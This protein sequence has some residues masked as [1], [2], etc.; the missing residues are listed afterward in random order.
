M[1]DARVA[2]MV[3]ARMEDPI[4]ALRRVSE[5]IDR[6]P[7]PDAELERQ[8]QLLA[9]HRAG[10]VELPEDLAAR[11]QPVDVEALGLKRVSID[12]LRELAAQRAATEQFAL[13]GVM[14]G[15][16]TTMVSPRPRAGISAR[17][18]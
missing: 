16:L 18:G 4:E 7:E 12:S 3:Y 6:A 14:D 10:N 2:C 13:K 11:I 17:S 8:L 9:L 5:V 15:E 1:A